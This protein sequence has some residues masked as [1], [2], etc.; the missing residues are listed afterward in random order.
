MKVSKLIF[1][2]KRCD[3]CIHMCVCLCSIRGIYFLFMIHT[4]YQW[5]LLLM[6]MCIL[7]LLFTCSSTRTLS[8]CMIAFN[9]LAP[10]RFEWNFRWF[11]F[12]VISVVDSWG[13]DCE[14]ALR[15]MSLDLTDDKSTLVQVMAW[16]HQ[17]TSHYLNQYWLR[18]LTP[19]GV[20]RPQWLTMYM[21]RDDLINK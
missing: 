10:G 2:Q 9:S 20:T 4:F 16:R 7:L 11:I 17:A 12:K 5:V 1:S 21:V 18:Y 13:I 8:V 15:W 19:Y 3:R 14:I 6:M